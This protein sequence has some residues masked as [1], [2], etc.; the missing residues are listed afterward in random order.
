MADDQVLPDGGEEDPGRDGVMPMD[1]MAQAWPMEGATIKLAHDMLVAPVKEAERP[2]KIPPT[3][4][5]E[6]NIGMGLTIF[7]PSIEAQKA[8]FTP[9]KLVD[10]KPVDA[11]A[12]LLRVFQGIY[13]PLKPKQVTE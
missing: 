10:E 5:G 6:V 2:W 4:A 1:R 13:L 9:Y 12:D 8:G 3:V 7:L 11:T